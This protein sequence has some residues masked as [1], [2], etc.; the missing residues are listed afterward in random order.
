MAASGWPIRVPSTPKF[1]TSVYLRPRLGRALTVA[2]SCV[3]TDKIILPVQPDVLKRLLTTKDPLSWCLILNKTILLSKRTLTVLD[4]IDMY[5]LNLDL[6][7]RYIFYDGIITNCGFTFLPFCEL[8]SQK[9]SLNRLWWRDEILAFG[10]RR[11]RAIG[12]NIKYAVAIR[13]K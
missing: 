10:V 2:S 9:N 1:S 4:D 8:M 11:R 7:F 6:Q 3:L 13:I 5:L 12:A